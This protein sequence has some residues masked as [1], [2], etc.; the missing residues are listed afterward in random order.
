MHSIAVSAGRD[1][2]RRGGR[3]RRGRAL[4][5]LAGEGV[6]GVRLCMVDASDTVRGRV[7]RGV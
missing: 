4:W 5:V 3:G 1:G 6:G 2:T 7:G